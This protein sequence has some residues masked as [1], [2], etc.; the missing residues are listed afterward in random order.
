MDPDGCDD[1]AVN[2][3]DE[4]LGP[5]GIRRAYDTTPRLPVAITSTASASSEIFLSESRFLDDAIA[6]RSIDVYCK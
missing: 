5:R 4:A 1:G 3:A 6:A 2:F